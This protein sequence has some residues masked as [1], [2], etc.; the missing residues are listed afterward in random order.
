[1]FTSSEKKLSQK[2]DEEK[3]YIWRDIEKIK[4]QITVLSASFNELSKNAPEHYKEIKQASKDTSYYKNRSEE[5][6]NLSK[7]STNEIIS[8]KDNIISINKNINDIFSEIKYESEQAKNR[9]QNIEEHHDAFQQTRTDAKVELNLLSELVDEKEELTAKITDI[10]LLVTESQ[11]FSLKLKSLVSNS[12][13]ERK[14]IQEIYF[15]VF[16]Y[17]TEDDDGNVEHIDGL[18]TKLENS[19]DAIK[20]KLQAI[21]EKSKELENHLVEQISNCELSAQN[22]FDDYIFKVE[23]QHRGIVKK[24]TS[25]LPKALTAGLSG[26]YEAKIEQEEKQLLQHEKTFNYSIISL[27][28]CSSLPIGFNIYRIVTSTPLP[29]IV[30]DT[31]LLLSMM[32]PLYTPIL[33]VAYSANKKY[34]LSKRLIE[35]Y[36]HKGVL[37]K[38]FEGLSTQIQEV[39]EESINKELRTKLLYNLLNVNSENPGKLISDYNKS[40][41]PLMDALDKSSKFADSLSKLERL[42]L[43]SPLIK[44]LSE[45]EEQKIKAKYEKTSELIEN[46]LNNKKEE[47]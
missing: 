38:T 26:A 36:T 17:K 19:Y 4:N 14:K 31:P 21:D 39:G 13:K 5:Q 30:K 12:E 23:A 27:V 29:D 7:E 44:H 9:L 3:E 18:V 24:I 32:L 28:I 35:E 25:L 8:Y 37:S 6:F 33:W 42:P 47:V 20:E 46:E 1:M 43:I 11:E 45:R 34:K 40:D 41:H 10:N 2:I 15:D 22:R 16:G